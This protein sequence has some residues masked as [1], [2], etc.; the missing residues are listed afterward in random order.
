MVWKS[1]DIH[2]CADAVRHYDITYYIP[3]LDFVILDCM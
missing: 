1:R 3:I 2:V